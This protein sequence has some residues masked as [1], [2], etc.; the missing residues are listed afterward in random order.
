MFLYAVLIGLIVGWIRKGKI[1]KI[2]YLTIKLP[3]L[4]VS[5]VVIQILIF[6]LKLGLTDLNSIIPDIMLIISYVL[7]LSGVILNLNIPYIKMILTGS[8]FNLIMMIL[9]GFKIGMTLDAAR[10]VYN[11]EIKQLLLADKIRYF[12]IIPQEQFYK[13]GFLPVGNA[14]IFPMILTI[15]DIIIYLGV[16][17]MIQKI[18]SDRNIRKGLNVRYSKKLFK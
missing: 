17:L 15:G 3:L 12:T 4:L 7:I 11:E 14:I 13:G 2:G 18:M 6:F 8:V 10:A 5:G 9:N 1:E 16:I